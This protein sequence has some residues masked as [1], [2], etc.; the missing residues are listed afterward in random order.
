MCSWLAFYIFI[1]SVGH[2]STM[3]DW[4]LESAPYDYT[5]KRGGCLERKAVLQHEI[6]NNEIFNGT[7]NQWLA[8]AIWN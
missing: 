5:Y 8:V 3:L 1:I 4:I 7:C 2:A 6:F